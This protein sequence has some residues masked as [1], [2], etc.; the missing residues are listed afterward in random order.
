M[1]VEKVEK[2]DNGTRLDL[3][4]FLREGYVDKSVSLFV[5]DDTDDIIQIYLSSYEYGNMTW[6]RN[7][8]ALEVHKWETEEDLE[9]GN[10]LSR[11]FPQILSDGLVNDRK[12][13]LVLMDSVLEDVRKSANLPSELREEIVRILESVKGGDL[14]IR[15]KRNVLP[16][17]TA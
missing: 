8:G 15:A 6:K 2:H 17:V 12:Y 10:F 9:E 11:H 4:S 16:A 5:S 1:K 7:V 14:R 13:E 3:A